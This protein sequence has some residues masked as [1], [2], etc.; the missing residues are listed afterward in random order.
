[1]S[2]R[3]SLVNTRVTSPTAGSD[4]LPQGTVRRSDSQLLRRGTGDK[5]GIALI[6]KDYRLPLKLG[7]A[8]LGKKNE[9]NEQ[10]R[11]GCPTLTEENMKN[12]IF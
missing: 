3:S 6:S 5:K 10:Q 12:L 1:M 4:V 2:T 8:M 7:I 9:I 11:K